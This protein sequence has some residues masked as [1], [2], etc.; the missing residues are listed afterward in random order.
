MH[1]AE[2]AHTL[3]SHLAAIFGDHEPIALKT[4]VEWS[5]HNSP[6]CEDLHSKSDS[7][8]S[9]RTV[10]TVEGKDVERAGAAAEN[11]V[12]PPQAPDGLSST[13]RSQETE[14]C[15][16]EW[17]AHDTDCET[18]HSGLPS[19]LKMTEFHDEKPSSGT[20]AGIPSIP[21]TNNMLNYPKD[22]GNPPNTPN[23]TSRG[24][25]Q[26]TAKNGGQWQ[27]TMHEVN[28][29]DGK[30]SPAPNTADRMSEMTTGDGPIPFLRK[31]PKNSVKHQHQSTC[32]IPR[33]NRCA[34]ANAQHPN[35]H[36]KPKI[37][38]PKHHRPL[39]EGER[40]GGAANGY[41]HNSSRQSTPQKLVAT[42]N[43]LE[44][45]VTISLKS[46]KPHSGEI[47]RVHLG[48]VHWHTDDVNGPGN[49]VNASSGQADESRGQADTL[50]MS[51][52]AKTAGVSDDDSMLRPCSTPGL[53]R[54]L[55][56]H[57][58]STAQLWS[59]ITYSSHSHTDNLP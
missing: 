9:V 17:I 29:N 19:E 4:P 16:R 13:D 48:S 45:L 40:V 26:E 25:V 37:H 41:T 44:A 54:S 47:P 35:G 23:G 42:S 12:K 15:G 6:L 5:D 49:G 58:S 8:D 1:H 28:Q 50:N 14:Q 3:F 24:D 46:E 36:L 7:A 21:N 39:L 18:G 59:L 34:N 51:Y 2:L 43:E 11:P 10:N 52:N 20:L 56:S 32:N 38:L 22:L 55:W 33:P 53:I 31:Q 30:A 57:R 27:R